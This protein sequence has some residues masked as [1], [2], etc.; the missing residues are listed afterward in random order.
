[1][2]RGNRR[3]K[4]RRK[5]E[6]NPSRVDL[7]ST[8]DGMHR[9][10]TT[11]IE[12]ETKIKVQKTARR[13]VGRGGARRS[14]FDFSRS[15]SLASARAFALKKSIIFYLSNLKKNKILK[16]KEAFEG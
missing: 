16:M 15:R 3:W 10:Y 11:L 4:G 1:L 12:R 13:G 8:K 5:E 9:I 6:R 7:A 14:H 2:R